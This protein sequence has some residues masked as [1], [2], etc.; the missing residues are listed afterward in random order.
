MTAA[1]QD[2]IDTRKAVRPRLALP[3]PWE[4]HPLLAAAVLALVGTTA[5]LAQVHRAPLTAEFVLL[6]GMATAATFGRVLAVPL[7]VVA[8]VPLVATGLQPASTV[9]GALAVT[10]FCLALSGDREGGFAWPWALWLG[11]VVALDDLRGIQAVGFTPHGSDVIGFEARLFGGVPTLELQHHLAGNGLTW[12]DVAI[13]LV[14]LMHSPAPLICGAVLWSRRRDLFLPF[15]LT[16]IL[17]G[18]AGLV[19][20]LVFPEAPPWLASQQHLLDPV[21]RITSEVIDHVGP[22]SSVYAGADPLPNAAMPSLHVAYPV[23]VAWW[24]ITAFG[25]GALW[26]AAY[27][28]VLTVGVVYL[29]EHWVVDVVVGIAY[30]AAAIAVVRRLTRSY[31]A[32]RSARKRIASG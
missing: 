2:G 8:G 9:G 15:V 24:T 25:R 1:P 10:V 29:G 32:S 21:R 30:A 18:A 12:Y 5:G 31:D 20:Y 11:A 16:L 22:L 7:L 27:P 17:T 4:R 19:T 28:A 13:S 14:Y 23:I 26:I 3:W 6:G